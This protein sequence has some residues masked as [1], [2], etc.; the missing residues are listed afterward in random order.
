MLLGWID[1][2]WTDRSD[3]GNTVIDAL[4]KCDMPAD[5]CR[6]FPHV[7]AAQSVQVVVKAFD[8]EW[9]A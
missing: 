4:A 7:V 2:D 8:Q 3:L 6:H 5:R 1:D 9:M